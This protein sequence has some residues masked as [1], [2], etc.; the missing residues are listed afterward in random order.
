MIEIFS[1][2]FIFLEDNLTGKNMK[3][4]FLL[5]ILL[6]LLSIPDRVNAQSSA[7]DSLETSLLTAKNDSAKVETLLS[8]SRSLYISW[9]KDAIGYAYQAMQLSIELN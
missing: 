7:I 4:Y 1:K 3:S 9:P 8:L 5:M 6:S 2:D